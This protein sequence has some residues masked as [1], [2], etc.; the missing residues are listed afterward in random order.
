MFSSK[1]FIFVLIALTAVCDAHKRVCKTICPLWINEWD[2]T[3]AQ[4]VNR[5]FDVSNG[6]Q[7]GICLKGNKLVFLG[8]QF[9]PNIK[10]LQNRCVCVEFETN[11]PE[12]CSE[13]RPDNRQCNLQK[14]VS[15]DKTI[16]EYLQNVI[17]AGNVTADGCCQPGHAKAIFL[18]KGSGLETNVCHC[19]PPK[20]NII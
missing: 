12:P 20:A 8:E 18:A 10:P 15:L 2:K 5:Y 16:K 11:F 4:N 9:A 1:V 13:N 17:A 3:I 6:P 19:V 14:A 7:D